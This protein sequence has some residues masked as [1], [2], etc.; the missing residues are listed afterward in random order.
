MSG[1]L[2]RKLK[3]KELRSF[4][5]KI[6]LQTTL[7]TMQRLKHEDKFLNREAQYEIV[8]IQSVSCVRISRYMYLSYVL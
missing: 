4:I 5:D 3:G 1:E 2:Q 7:H 8:L 6:E